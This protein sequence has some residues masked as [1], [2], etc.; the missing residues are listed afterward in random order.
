MKKTG[1]SVITQT[2]SE[3]KI[4][5]ARSSVSGLQHNLLET[6]EDH[7]TMIEQTNVKSNYLINKRVIWRNV[8]NFWKQIDSQILLESKFKHHVTFLRA[9]SINIEGELIVIWTNLKSLV[10]CPLISGLKKV[11]GDGSG[12]RERQETKYYKGLWDTFTLAN[13]FS[14]W[15]RRF[16]RQNLRTQTSQ[17]WKLICPTLNTMVLY[18]P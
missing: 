13:S 10:Y 9:L 7:C 6:I 3:K 4:Y 14:A 11:A 16:G 2:Y 5:V 8:S 12:K 15:G 18:L 1:I 17:D